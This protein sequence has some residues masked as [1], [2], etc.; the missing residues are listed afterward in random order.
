MMGPMII[1]AVRGDI[2]RQSTDA[3]VNA[4]NS[5]LLGGGGPLGGGRSLR[6]GLR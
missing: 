5:G 3:I 4:A 2:T 6:R 1:E